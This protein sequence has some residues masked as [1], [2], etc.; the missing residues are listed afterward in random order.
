M[1]QRRPL[2]KQAEL[3]ILVWKKSASELL[4][5]LFLAALIY[6]LMIWGQIGGAGTVW[7]PA[8]ERLRSGAALSR[9][10]LG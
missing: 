7:V 3:V 4:A 8:G 1:A 6:F 5:E 2:K 10:Q 9:S